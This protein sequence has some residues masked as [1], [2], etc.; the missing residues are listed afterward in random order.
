[1]TDLDEAG[2]SA[3]IKDIKQIFDQKFMQARQKLMKSSRIR[4]CANDWLKSIGRWPAESKRASLE[5]SVDM[6]QQ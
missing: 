6:E 4:S 3:L 1:M 5:D 2:T